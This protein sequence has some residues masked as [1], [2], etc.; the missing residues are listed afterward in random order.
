MITGAAS[1]IGRALALACAARGMRLVLADVE[2]TGLAQTALLASQPDCL[3]HRTD[4][5]RAEDVEELARL[6]YSASSDVALLFNNAGVANGGWAWKSTSKDWAWVIGVNLMGVAHGIQSFV[7]RMLQQGA[8]AHIVNTA[9]AAGL[10]SVPRAAAYCASKH[11]V[12][13]L[14]E[15]LQQELRMKNAPVGVSVLC[16]SFVQTGIGD[17]ERHRPAHFGGPAARVVRDEQLERAMRSAALTAD[18]IAT[19]TFEGIQAG[20]FYILPHPQVLEEVER[21]LRAIMER[22]GPASDTVA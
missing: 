3:Q 20:D 11:G 5:S 7:P 9:S 2:Q 17:S 15:C 6:A 18:D 19:A 12:V 4:V 16:P 1:G 14:S 21:R 8:P 22:R 13:T 10:F